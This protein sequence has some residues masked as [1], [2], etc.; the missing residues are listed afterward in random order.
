VSESLYQMTALVDFL[1]L[2]IWTGQVEEE[3]PSSAIIVAP[4][5]AGKTTLLENLTCVQAPF[6]GDLT[7]RQ[8]PGILKEDKVTHILLGDM[9]SILGHKESTVKLTI[10]VISQMTGEKLLH[11]PWTG[12]A[13]PPRQIGLITAIPPEDFAKQQRH[14]KTGGFA[15][16]F[17][18]VKYSYKASTVAAIHRFIASNK[19]AGDKVKPFLLANPGRWVVELPEK[20]SEQI[21]DFGLTLK[22]DPL[23]FRAHRHLRALVKAE[24]RRNC[25]PIVQP[26]DFE[27]VQ[28]YCEFFSTEGKEL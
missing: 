28:N 4:A 3:R 11:N 16:R 21:K 17:L 27:T 19:Y 1:K 5:G 18:I 9:L 24:A 10:R 25:R 20:I 2:I 26:K 7:S 14:I 6:V 12:E 22:K 8:I 23:G 15:S 13:I